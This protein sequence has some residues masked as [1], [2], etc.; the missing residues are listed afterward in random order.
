MGTSPFYAL[1]FYWSFRRLPPELFEAARLEGMGALAMWRR[2]PMPLV[3]PTYLPL[4]IYRNGFE[5][6]RYGTRPRPRSRC[7]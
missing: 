6:L 2:V 4:F 1:L 7:S 3:R 5:Y